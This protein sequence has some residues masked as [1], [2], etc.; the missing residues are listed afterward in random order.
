MSIWACAIPY[1]D[2]LD[3]VNQRVYDFCLIYL[4]SLW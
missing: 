1:E 2:L 3:E 4:V